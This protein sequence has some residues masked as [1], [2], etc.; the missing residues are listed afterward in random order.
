MPIYFAKSRCGVQ[1][2]L[3]YDGLGSRHLSKAYLQ[4]LRSAGVQIAVFFPVK[5]PFLHRKINYRNHRKILIIDG[6][7]GFVGGANIGDEYLGQNLEIALA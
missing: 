1:V 3:I 2:R 4:K 6:K 7:I 5:L